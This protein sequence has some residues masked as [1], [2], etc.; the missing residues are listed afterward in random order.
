[1]PYFHMPSH[2]FSYMQAYNIMFVLYVYINGY[3][4]VITYVTTSSSSS[5]L[6]EGSPEISLSLKV[7]IPS[8]PWVMLSD[9]PYKLFVF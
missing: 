1:M 7:S 4:I 6:Y 3:S 5:G 2:N 8:Y 9:T